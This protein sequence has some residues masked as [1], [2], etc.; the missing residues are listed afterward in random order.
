MKIVY[1]ENKKVKVRKSKRIVIKTKVRRAK[2]ERI[3][4]LKAT[5]KMKK[6]NK[7]S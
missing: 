4:I 5:D 7:K 2:I 3:I 6:M 1:R